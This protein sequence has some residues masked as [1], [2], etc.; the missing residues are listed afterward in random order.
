[1]TKI[2]Q[3]FNSIDTYLE[4]AYDV[5]N[6]AK[7]KGLDP[8]NFV[9]MPLAKGISERVE[10]LVSVFSPQILKSGVAQRIQSLEDEYGK[11]DWRVGLQIAY[12]VANEDFCKFKDKKES[13]EIGIRVGFAYITLG[14]ISAPLEGFIDISIKKRKD[15]EEYIAM[16]FAGPVRA[17]GG[18][19]GAVSVLI[20]D[21]VRKKM[22][23]NIY[24]PDEIEV[25][26]YY[27]ELLDY[28]DRCVRLQYMPSEE[29]VKFLIEHIGMEISGDPTEKLEVSNY[30]DLPR[31]P[32]NRIR[33]GMCLVVGE[34]IIQKAPKIN[35]RI[36][37][38][39]KDFGMEQ[40]LFLKEF[41]DLQKKI[42][43]KA[44]T[45]SDKKKEKKKDDE[46]KPKILPNY[47]FIQDIVAGRP[48]FTFP[49]A[50]GGFRLRY[51]RCRTSGFAS[52][53]MS[54]QTMEILDK[55]VAVGTQL[56]IER[57]GKATVIT[58]CDTLEPPIVKLKDGSVKRLSTQEMA[59]EYTSEIE[60]ILHLGDL[61][62]CYGEFSENNHPLV[63]NG[64]CEEEWA[65]ELIEKI[66]K[67]K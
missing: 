7:E 2:E 3:Y 21:Y 35:K 12:E 38:W 10:G 58:A 19:A 22:G 66:N 33:G 65:L 55:F 24:D 25:K 41:L 53:S 31:I 46:D 67:K 32:T 39:G 1:M 36:E 14:V 30:K 45:S 16:N 50:K 6:K 44:G 48:V 56:K 27:T 47:K 29:E 20:G 9:E 59:K 63:P 62:I 18:T 42:K 11:L 43:A 64:Y 37:D 23:Y 26:R 61:L 49:M 4:K 60:E 5:A 34:C 13:M 57:P 52:N 15:G 51:G 8:K 17:A 54:A 40:W 28:N